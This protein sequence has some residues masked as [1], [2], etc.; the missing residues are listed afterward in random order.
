MSDQNFTLPESKLTEKEQEALAA[1][2]DEESLVELV[3]DNL[4]TGFGYGRSYCGGRFQDD[5]LLSV[6]YQAMM[7]AARRFRPGRQRLV[8]FCK[9]FI[10]GELHRAWKRKAPVGTSL[11]DYSVSRQTVWSPDDEQDSGVQELEYTSFDYDAV[12]KETF[13]ARIKPWLPRLTQHERLIVDLIFFGGYNQADA[14]T[15][16]GVER[17]AVKQVL[18]RVYRKFSRWLK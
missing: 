11:P 9:P 6:V 14:S 10:R 7:S 2:G 16:L 3:M 17:Q 15:L 5:E 4:R 12:D 18:R 8:A 13:V 1:K